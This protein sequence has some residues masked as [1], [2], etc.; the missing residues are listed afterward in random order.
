MLSKGSRPSSAA[1]R[2]ILLGFASDVAQQGQSLSP[3]ACEAFV[4]VG[5][6]QEA[7][8]GK[9]VEVDASFDRRHHCSHDQ[10]WHL[11]AAR[12]RS[13][14]QNGLPGP[15]AGYLAYGVCLPLSMRPAH[16]SICSF[17]QA[18]S[19]DV[20]PLNQGVVTP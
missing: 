14:F 13:P 1:V 19:I 8:H 12:Q 20:G 17:Q 9:L 3:P 18:T 15:A 2:E 10:G 16:L 4:D 5:S 7:C 11:G 6:G